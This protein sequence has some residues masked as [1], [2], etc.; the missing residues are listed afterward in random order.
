MPL[1]GFDFGSIFG[2]AVKCSGICADPD[3]CCR[4]VVAQSCLT[5]STNRG[6]KAIYVSEGASCVLLRD[7][8]TRAPVVRFK[9]ARGA[10]D[11]NFFLEDRLNFETLIMVLTNR[12]DLLDFKPLSA[13]LWGKIFTLDLA[14]SREMQWG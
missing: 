6:C 8:M 3:G 11:L 9:S 13:L 4:V 7:G 12:A 14:A 10:A 5:A 2:C 1:E